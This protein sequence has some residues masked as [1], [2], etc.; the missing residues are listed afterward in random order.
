MNFT[1]TLSNIGYIGIK[2]ILDKGKLNH[3]C[4]SIVQAY[5]L[6]ERIEELK[7]KRDRVM[8]APV[9]AINMHP[10]IK[11]STIKRK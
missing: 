7:V 5:H 3:S 4:V 1:A 6:R 8:I 9:D 2:R 10:S 11:L